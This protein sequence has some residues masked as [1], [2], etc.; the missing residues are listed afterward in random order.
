MR[1]VPF[2][3]GLG[4]CVKMCCCKVGSAQSGV[5]FFVFWRGGYGG[6]SRGAVKYGELWYGGFGELC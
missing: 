6:V 1:W 3:L 5:L 4:G 2:W